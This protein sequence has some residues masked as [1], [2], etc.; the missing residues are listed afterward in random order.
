MDLFIVLLVGIPVCLLVLAAAGWLWFIG[1][2]FVYLL[3]AVA[4]LAVA[5]MVVAICIWC[6]PVIVGIAIIGILVIAKHARN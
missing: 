3:E 4:V 5:G 6:W 1:K 2:I